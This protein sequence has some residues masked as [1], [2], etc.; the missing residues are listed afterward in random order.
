[1][2]TLPTGFQDDAPAE[3]PAEETA[4]GTVDTTME[5]AQNTIERIQAWFTNPQTFLDDL[6]DFGSAWGPK[7]LGA[8]AVYVIGMWIARIIRGVVKKALMRA[9]SEEMLANFVA[10]M[11]HIGLI[12]FVVIMVMGTIGIPTTGFAAIIA[13]A[14]FA[15]G[16]ALQGSLGNFASGVMVMIFKPFKPGD[17]I[18]G[19]GHAGVVEDVGIFATIMKTGDNKK[20]IVPNGEL[21]DS[22]LVNY[23]ANPTRRIDMVFGIGYDD[24]IDK[25]RD[26][27]TRIVE[28]DERILKDPAP[29]IAVSEL[30]DSSVNFVC[31]PWV[32]SADYWAVKFDTTERVKKEFDAAGLS[33][34]YPQRDVHMHEVK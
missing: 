21:T 18:E 33:I 27:L 19:A 9:K 25:A 5:A 7:L 29:Q 13:A 23:S 32:N 16:F 31:R 26:V 12:V 28:A 17:F 15:V 2:F 22:S 10:N 1:M 8:V 4:E 20:I 3:A 24:D 30:A 34:P 6:S 14:G 11:V